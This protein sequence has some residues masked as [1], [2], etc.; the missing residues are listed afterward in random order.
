MSW[1]QGNKNESRVSNPFGGTPAAAQ[2]TP[3]GSFGQPQHTTQANPFGALGSS[4]QASP[5]GGFGQATQPSP[6]GAFAAPAQQ[7]S[8]FGTVPRIQQQTQSS[9]F[10]GKGKGKGIQESQPSASMQ[11]E[12]VQVTRVSNPFA[13]VGA[14]PSQALS[15]EE[16][17]SQFKNEYVKKKGYPFSCYGLAEEPPTLTGDI[18]PAELRWYLSQTNPDIHKAIS[19]RSSLLNEDF[20]EFLRAAGDGAPVLIKRAGPYRIPDPDF[21]AFVPRTEFS[22]FDSSSSAPLTDADRYIFQTKTVP[23]GGSLPLVP[24]PVEMR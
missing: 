6:F 17:V 21:P 9:P 1:R 24:P 7:S 4:S 11:D 3:F 8:P 18:S 22:L 16:A 19:E 13:A 15:T 2:S 12:T 10:E 14:A 5:F 23:E 20:T